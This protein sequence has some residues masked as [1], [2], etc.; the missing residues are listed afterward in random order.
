M[1][2]RRR[3]ARRGRNPHSA[4]RLPA[5]R[6]ALGLGDGSAPWAQ[7]IRLAA[8]GATVFAYD[9]AGYG[10]SSAATT[11]RDGEHLVEEL[12]RTLQATQLPQP[13]L[14]VGHSLGGQLVLLYARLHP[15]EVAG[16]VLVDGR[17]PTFTDRCVA[18]LGEAACVLPAADAAQLPQPMRAE[19]TAAEET[20]RQL[21]AAPAFPAVPVVMLSRTVGSDGA[22]FQALW[23]AAQGDLAA[24]LSATHR[25][26]PGASHY[27]QRDKPD[28]VAGAIAEVIAAL[29]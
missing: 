17:P 25:R 16:V 7:V 22:A 9:R 11:P 14:L 8:P 4:D 12:R 5:N 28:A 6:S 2:L 3:L 26:V 21:L 20:A 10:R 29:R 27:V 13:Y 1:I 23:D 19:Y 18:A 15:A 24:E